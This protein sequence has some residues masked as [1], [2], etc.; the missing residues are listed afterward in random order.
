M[1]EKSGLQ[2][3]IDSIPLATR[4]RISVH[5]GMNETSLMTEVDTARYHAIVSENEVVSI[6]SPRYLLVQ[7]KEAFEPI[8]KGLDAMNIPY[9]H[10]LF[11][12]K[13]KSWLSVLVANTIDSVSIGFKAMNSVDGTT[14]LKYSF[15]L[16]KFKSWIK[17]VGYRKACANGMIIRVPLDRAE[18]VQAEVR[19]KVEK[20]LE[21][22]QRIV[23]MGDKDKEIE[24]VQYIV[25]AVS[26]LSGSVA[27][28][29]EK[30]QSREIGAKEA[31]ELIAK[32]VGKRMAQKIY[33]RFAF[34]NPSLWGL[35]NS[36]TNVASHEDIAESTSN[37]LLLKASTMLQDEI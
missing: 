18:F 6:V 24:A 5:A 23:H 13:G 17:L 30:A 28:I 11:T 4:H 34:E 9:Q 10:N 35:Y 8:A 14:A 31:K 33:N 29:I 19:T 7:H 1:W 16:T 37:G 2:E 36:I 20:L 21:Q 3:A 25:E 12:F 32:Y 22:N 27:K 26:L 15:A